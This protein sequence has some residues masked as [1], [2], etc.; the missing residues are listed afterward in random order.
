ML[1]NDF[2]ARRFLVI[3]DTGG[4]R[5]VIPFPAAAGLGIEEGSSDGLGRIY[6]RSRPF[7]D[8]DGPGAP[9][10][11]RAF[12]DSLAIMRWDPTSGTV[13]TAGWVAA[14]RT[15]ISGRSGDKGGVST[16]P[17]VFTPG[18]IWGVAPD[19]A[20]ARVLPEPYRVMWYGKDS[21]TVGEVQPY[22]PIPVTEADR[23][24]HYENFFFGDPVRMRQALYNVY[25]RSAAVERVKAF[26]ADTTW[27]DVP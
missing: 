8:V 27:P 25:D 15:R 26:V 7:G 22:S 20:V 6:F 23:Q 14:P 19:G 21:V 3:D 17:P 16:D 2:F 9:G 13:D 12:P 4:A 24:A 1:L 10:G 18:E 5:D 11:V